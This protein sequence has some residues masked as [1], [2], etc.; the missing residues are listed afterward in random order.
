MCFCTLVN[1]EHLNMITIP[2]TENQCN[3]YIKSQPICVY[4]VNIFVNNVKQIILSA[5]HV[6]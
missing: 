3:N 2:L 5:T 6:K 1:S 4:N